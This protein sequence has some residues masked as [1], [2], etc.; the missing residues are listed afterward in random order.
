MIV[1]VQMCKTC[2]KDMAKPTIVVQ[3]NMMILRLRTLT[4]HIFSRIKTNL[5][6]MYPLTGGNNFTCKNSLRS[7]EEKK[8]AE[9]K[10]SL[11]INFT[12]AFI[13]SLKQKVHLYTL[14]II[15]IHSSFARQG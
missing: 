5:M 10:A 6:V 13:T 15:V 1:D 12:F 7:Q 4:Q 2:F 14:I 11:T 9:K 3:D 8:K